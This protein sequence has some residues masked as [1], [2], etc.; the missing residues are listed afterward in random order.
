MQEDLTLGKEAWYY[1]DNFNFP[2]TCFR[3][4]NYTRNKEINHLAA[5]KMVFNK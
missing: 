2:N 4:R 3:T 5:I 1:G